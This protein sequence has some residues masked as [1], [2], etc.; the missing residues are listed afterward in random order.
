MWKEVI[1][2]V[3]EDEFDSDSSIDSIEALLREKRQT[4]S[5]KKN[6]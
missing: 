2:M 3:P 1:D 5:C 6:F 4:G